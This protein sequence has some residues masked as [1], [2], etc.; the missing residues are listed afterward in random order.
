MAS[1][2]KRRW[3]RPD[4]T[5]GEKWTVRY[6]DGDAHPQRTFTLKKEAQAFQRQVEQ[7]I[8]AGTHVSRRTSRKLSDL[9]D[10]VCTDLSRR[11]DTG[12]VGAGYLDQTARSLRYASE[13]MGGDIVAE[14]KWQRVEQFGKHLMERQSKWKGRKFSNTTVRVVLN[15]L[16]MAFDYGIRRGYAVRN[17]VGDAIKELGQLPAKPIVPFTQAE[18]QTVVAAIEDR[19]PRNSHRGQALLRA[20]VYLGTMC[21]MRRGEIMAL[22]W[23]DVDLSRRQIT[24]RHNL[25][26]VDVLKSPKTNAGKRTIPMPALV[27][28]ALEQ[29]R[30]F[31]VEDD[32]GLIFRT[33]T[34]GI[35]RASDF[36]ADLWHVLLRK[37]GFP[38]ADGRWRH[39]HATR[40]FAGSAWLDAGV[41]L[42]EVSRLMGHANMQIT[43]RIYSHAITEVHHRAQELD[44]CAGFLTQGIAHPLRIAA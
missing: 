11:V 10:E 16:K 43:A 35:I 18:M 6:K 44:Q 32:R 17:I 42:P 8:E 2:A 34:G 28:N 7:D 21:G 36:Y 38:P 20:A 25:T 26:V 22:S 9:I 13:F 24:V 37:A 1:V 27:A 5:I 12:Q 14:M 4:G 39:F 30:P 19:D 29:W 33:K 23:D 41:P 15:A 31:V 3:K 40:H